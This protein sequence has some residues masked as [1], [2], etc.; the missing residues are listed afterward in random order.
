MFLKGGNSEY[1]QVR[2]APLFLDPLGSYKL[3]DNYA[4][5]I[6]LMAVVHNRILLFELRI[7]ENKYNSFSLYYEFSEGKKKHLNK[8]GQ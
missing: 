1:E 4:T 8:D 6:Y 5:M 3:S 7:I 2:N